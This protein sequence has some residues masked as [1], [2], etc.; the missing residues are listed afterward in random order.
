MTS[1]KLDRSLETGRVI[2]TG[3]L[4]DVND[5]SYLVL[6]IGPAGAQ[7][8]KTAHEANLEGLKR[9]MFATLGPRVSSPKLYIIPSSI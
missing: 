7:Y 6:D 5:R 4:G 9:D 8:V 1:V 3:V 2:K